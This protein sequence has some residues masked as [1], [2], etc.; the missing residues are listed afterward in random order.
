MARFLKITAELLSADEKLAGYLRQARISSGRNGGTFV[1]SY[2]VASDEWKKYGIVL[3][4]GGMILPDE[5]PGNL[6]DLIQHLLDDEARRQAEAEAAA[7]MEEARLETE[8]AS[9]AP[10]VL[11]AFELFRINGGPTWKLQ[12][13]EKGDSSTFRSFRPERILQACKISLG[14]LSPITEAPL[15][16][17]WTSDEV[18][19]LT[20]I[21]RQWVEATQPRR[22]RLWSLFV[23]ACGVFTKVERRVFC[24]SVSHSMW[25]GRVKNEPDWEIEASYL[26]GDETLSREEYSWL[27]G[28]SREITLPD[29]YVR[30]A[31]DTNDILEV[32]PLPGQNDVLVVVGKTGSRRGV[33][34][35]G[36]WFRD[37]PSKC[38]IEFWSRG[39]QTR[40]QEVF[41]N[42]IRVESGWVN[43]DLWKN[44]RELAIRAFKEAGVENPTK[45]YVEAL[46]DAYSKMI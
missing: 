41:L 25:D 30:V 22:D 16:F 20:A 14:E 33:W 24:S 26:V 19:R 36:E 15:V 13:E 37:H 4:K 46:T 42:G 34:S 27:K 12:V 6:K 32:L 39:T 23:E 21:I 9:F 2:E 45:E 7:R 29:G 3:P 31:N 44:P 38:Q 10:S 43:L 5:D 11:A 40:I 17:E 8:R 1:G 28:R 35:F 18:D